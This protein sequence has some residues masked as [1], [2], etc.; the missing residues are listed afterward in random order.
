MMPDSDTSTCPF[1]ETTRS[2]FNSFFTIFIVE[3]SRVILKKTSGEEEEE[4]KEDTSYINA[5]Y[6]EVSIRLQFSSVSKFYVLLYDQICEFI[7]VYI[8]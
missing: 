8:F 7:S 2:G 5:N 1:E 6:L 4:E 3:K